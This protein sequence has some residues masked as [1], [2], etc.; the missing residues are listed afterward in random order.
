M[1]GEAYC[2]VHHPGMKEKREAASKRGGRTGGRGRGR[3]ELRD[4]RR[5]LRELIDRLERGVAD[6]RVASV[7]IQG[8]NV[9][10]R[11]VEQERRL[12]ETE[13]FEVRLRRLEEIARR[14]LW[15]RNA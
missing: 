4:V 2:Y 13:E 12:K 5:R 6:P 3:Q 10:M 14:K 1:R 8:W 9:Y 7:C 11:V 15:T